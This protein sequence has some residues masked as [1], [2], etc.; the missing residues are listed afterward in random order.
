MEFN[1]VGK[2][3]CYNYPNGNSLSYQDLTI[4]S[5]SH[6]LVLGPSGS[7]KTTLLNMISGLLKPDKGQLSFGNTDLYSM[8][9]SEIDRFRGNHLGIVFQTPRFL[10][11]LSVKENLLSANYFAGKKQDHEKMFF[12]L[13]GLGMKGAEKKMISEFSQGELQ[14]LSIARA[15]MNN[16]EILIADEPSSSLDDQNCHEMISL[17]ESEAREFNTTLLIVSH[18]ARIKSRFENQI[19][20]G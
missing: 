12:L 18:D 8:N 7:G 3:L 19:P 10:S 1:L 4:D 6:W 16:P 2:G 13:E 5:G 11:G 9:P 17:L 15:L 20:L 14:R